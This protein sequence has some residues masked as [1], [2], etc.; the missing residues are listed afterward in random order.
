VTEP[1]TIAADT[2]AS[3]SI[4]EIR[5][6]LVDNDAP[7]DLIDQVLSNLQLGRI[8]PLDRRDR[9]VVAIA[10]DFCSQATSKRQVA[11]AL[12]RDIVFPSRPRWGEEFSAERRALYRARLQELDRFCRENAVAIPSA[13]TL[14]NILDGSRTPGK[15]KKTERF[16]LA[17]FSA[18]KLATAPDLVDE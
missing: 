7:S 15:R 6:A 3:W 12:S 16:Q 14:R 11:N 5:R 4:E 18:K 1:A 2:T 8:S 10:A 17:N 13:G 9:M